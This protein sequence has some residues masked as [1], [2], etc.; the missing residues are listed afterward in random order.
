MP[1]FI[2]PLIIALL[3]FLSFNCNDS[4][5]L[6]RLNSSPNTDSINQSYQAISVMLALNYNYR[7]DDDHAAS[8][9]VVTLA[10]LYTASMIIVSATI[11]LFPYHHLA[12]SQGLE[13]AIVH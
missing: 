6:Q 8:L 12:L 1:A 10:L 5:G 9:T 7:C 2:L 3:L 4:V 11:F 13:E